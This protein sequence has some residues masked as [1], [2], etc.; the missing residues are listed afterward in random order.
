MAHA[1]SHGPRTICLGCGDPL[2][3]LDV[4]R[5]YCLVCRSELAKGPV[6]W[7]KRMAY[8]TKKAQA[9]GKTKP[10]VDDP[11]AGLRDDDVPSLELLQSLRRGNE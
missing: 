5:Q 7:G 4:G 8:L 1:F 9:Q 3:S 2:T 11:F 10:K 6:A